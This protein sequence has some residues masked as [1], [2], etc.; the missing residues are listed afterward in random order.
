MHGL[1]IKDSYV[2]FLKCLTMFLILSSMML[3]MKSLAQ[4]S[5]LTVNARLVLEPL[6]F[7]RIFREEE[8]PSS[9]L[10]RNLQ[11]SECL[12]IL[13]KDSMRQIKIWEKNAE[14]RR[15]QREAD[16]GAVTLWQSR[17]MPRARLSWE[18]PLLPLNRGEQTPIGKIQLVV[19][20]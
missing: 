10:S 4:N 3:P 6:D 9:L 19:P 20:F 13:E 14:K 12:N 1:R 16:Y 2:T 7:M 5:Q 11:I 15:M 8:C 17:Q 18:I